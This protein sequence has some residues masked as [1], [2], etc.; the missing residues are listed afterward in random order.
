VDRASSPLDSDTVN[1]VALDL[2]TASKIVDL[3]VFADYDE[4]GH[5]LCQEVSTILPMSE[6]SDGDRV[7]TVATS[8]TNIMSFRTLGY[9]VSDEEELGEQLDINI[10]RDGAWDIYRTIGG[11]SINIITLGGIGSSAY[12]K[13]GVL[14]SMVNPIE[15]EVDTCGCGD[16]FLALFSGAIA[17]NHSLP[18]AL[19]LGN[20][21]GRATA[22]KLYGADAP[23]LGDIEREIVKYRAEHPG[24]LE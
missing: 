19:A 22:R 10:I 8:R 15:E 11:N 4:C 12:H 1:K 23:T 5:P 14:P 6:I 18:T 9:T 7:K 13:D 24:E 17:T 20:M 16:A 3:I 2:R 21:A